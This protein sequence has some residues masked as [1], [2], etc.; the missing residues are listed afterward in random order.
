MLGYFLRER[1]VKTHRGGPDVK[2]V[3]LLSSWFSSQGG[4]QA[5]VLQRLHR[6]AGHPW[7]GGDFIVGPGILG[8]RRLH[9]G[10]GHLLL[11][12]P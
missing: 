3:P 10:P 12:K 6:G 2:G 7:W 8:G 1:I 4:R 9:L 5:Q 11:V